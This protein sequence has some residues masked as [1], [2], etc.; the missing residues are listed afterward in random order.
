MAGHTP[1][2]VLRDELKERKRV[3]RGSR[4]CSSM[5]LALGIAIAITLYAGWWFLY[6]QLAWKP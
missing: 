3:R 4:G 2:K 6:Y 5:D 1:F